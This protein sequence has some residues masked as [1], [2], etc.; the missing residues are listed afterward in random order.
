MSSCFKF[1]QVVILTEV[2]CGLASLPTGRLVIS[3]VLDVI[4]GMFW[5]KNQHQSEDAYH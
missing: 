2:E 3:L 1:D 4:Y 5:K